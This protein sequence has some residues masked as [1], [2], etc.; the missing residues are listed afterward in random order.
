MISFH[1][2]E[3]NTLT[4]AALIRFDNVAAYIAFIPY[5]AISGRLFGTKTPR[6]PS[7]TAIEPKF[8]NPHNAKVEITNAF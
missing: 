1:I 8:A 5:L 7:K 4:I 6:P 2:N 3:K